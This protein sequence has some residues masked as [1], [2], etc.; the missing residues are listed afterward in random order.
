MKSAMEYPL[1]APPDG[2]AVSL[3]PVGA[4]APAAAC[5]WR[6]GMCLPLCRAVIYDYLLTFHGV[7]SR[8]VRPLQLLLE[9]ALCMLFL[10]SVS[11]ISHQIISLKF[12]K[13][14]KISI[15][16]KFDI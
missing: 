10:C 8:G 6:V 16:I 7:S 13:K 9:S 12:S 3:M 2:G 11:P 5:C 15:D 14:L 1:F 4:L